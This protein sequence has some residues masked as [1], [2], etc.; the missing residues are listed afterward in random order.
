[1]DSYQ[2]Q[3]LAGRGHHILFPILSFRCQVQMAKDMMLVLMESDIYFL[4]K[5]NDTQAM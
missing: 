3:V 1:M 4:K 5:K 2:R